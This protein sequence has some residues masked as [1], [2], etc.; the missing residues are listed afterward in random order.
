ME[1]LSYHLRDGTATAA[2]STAA[3]PKVLKTVG[4]P[5]ANTNNADRRKDHLI[6]AR[7][8]VHIDLSSVTEIPI[9]LDVDFFIE[10]PQ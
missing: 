3:T 5:A 2:S 1:I 4:D 6:F 10:L 9:A 8:R 7:V